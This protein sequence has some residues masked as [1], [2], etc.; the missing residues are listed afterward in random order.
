MPRAVIHRA[1][2]AATLAPSPKNLY[3][4]T[5]GWAY[6]TWKPVFYPAEVPVRAFL[7]YYASRL[8]AVEVNY[9][10]RK[11]PEPALV[12]SWM[13]ATPPGFRFAFKAPELITHRQRLRD[14]RAAL[15][16]FVKAL[17]PA[18]RA[19]KLGPL[20]FQL[21]PNF[22][23]NAAR[24][25]EFLAA[26]AFGRGTGRLKVALEVRHDSWLSEE[27]YGILRRH[28]AALCVA[29]S[30]SF[31]TPD[32]STGPFRYYRLRRPGGYSARK[33]GDFAKGFSAVA[34]EEEVFVFLKHED[35]PTGAL[36]ALKLQLRAYNLQRKPAA[37]Q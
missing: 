24:L 13:E 22:K 15:A 14:S 3:V 12:R 8:T 32:V 27:I 6:T 18:R 16:A 5:S 33:L 11:L 19:N 37:R 28:R 2:V 17:Q 1:E 7:Q 9:T 21:P 34:D 20:L 29:E 23:A 25:N 10:F 26:P 30:E 31:V 4:G 35:E 36:N